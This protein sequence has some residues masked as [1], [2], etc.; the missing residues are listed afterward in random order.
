M[1][2]KEH[3]HLL[4]NEEIYLIDSS[5]SK[6]ESEKSEV[7]GVEE[8]VE[9][10]EEKVE[11]EKSKVERSEVKVEN[12]E[13]KEKVNVAFVSNSNNGAEM[14]LLQKIIGACNLEEGD[15]KISQ[16]DEPATY[17]KAVIFTEKASIFYQPTVENDSIVLYSKPLNELMHSKEEKGKLWGALKTFI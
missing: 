7:E 9:R 2:D 11:S 8:K 3:L 14:E 6:V 13:G 17:E 12:G 16:S 4:I 15:Y 10:I 5:Q 1:I